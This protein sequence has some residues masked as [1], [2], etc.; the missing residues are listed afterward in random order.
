MLGLLSFLF[1]L[2]LICSAQITPT[3][4][5][6]CEAGYLL[7]NITGQ[8]D[9]EFIPLWIDNTSCDFGCADNGIECNTPLKVD[10]LAVSINAA[11]FVVV[12]LFF[13]VLS[14]NLNVSSK[15]FYIMKYF[16]M[17]LSFVYIIPGMGMMAGIYYFGQNNIASLSWTGWIGFIVVFIFTIL[18][19]FLTELEEY[20][21][22]LLKAG[23]W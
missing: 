21:K 13:F 23:K 14:M 3:T 22:G 8:I 12:A 18:V 16:Y 11:I 1:F 20:V 7:T 5:Y 17:A 4:T 6:D 10:K 19:L 15:R 9:G 2:P